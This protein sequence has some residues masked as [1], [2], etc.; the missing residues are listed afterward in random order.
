MMSKPPYVEP[1]DWS[2]HA[3]NNKPLQWSKGRKNGRRDPSRVTNSTSALT[4]NSKHLIPRC[5][6]CRGEH[7]HAHNA[8]YV[9]P[10]CPRF[11]TSFAPL[12]YPHAIQGPAWMKC[13]SGTTSVGFFSNL[14][15]HIFWKTILAFL[16]PG[17]LHGPGSVQDSQNLCSS[18]GLTRGGRPIQSWCGRLWNQEGWSYRL[19]WKGVIH[20]WSRKLVYLKRR[21]GVMGGSTGN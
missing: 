19:F 18:S 5:W 13:R 1:K 10:H 7:W 6:N 3:Q 17:I 15:L 4:I 8:P 21:S 20:L 14:M 11:G 2:V 9:C 16:I 12:D